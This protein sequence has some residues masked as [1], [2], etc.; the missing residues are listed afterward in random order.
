MQNPQNTHN[1]MRIKHV[2]FI[3]FCNISKY[4]TKINTGH[5]QAH[6]PGSVR[7][8]MNKEK[9]YQE[10]TPK[11]EEAQSMK[12]NYNVLHRE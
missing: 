4:V 3:L 9:H 10:K 2:L 5:K 11:N 12:W 6:K 8:T 7:Q 1:I